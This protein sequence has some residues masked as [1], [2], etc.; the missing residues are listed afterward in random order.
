MGRIAALFAQKFIE[1]FA[2]GSGDAVDLYRRVGLDPK[3][4]IEPSLM[5]EDSEFYGLLEH[6]S[7]LGSTGRSIAVQVGSSMRCDDYGAFGLS[8]KS[9]PNLLESFQR[10]ERFGKVVTSLANFRVVAGG[11]SAFMEVIPDWDDRLGAV[12]TK[13]LAVAAATALSREVCQ[14]ELD[15][16]SVSFTH[17]APVDTS[18]FEAHFECPVTFGASRDGFEIDQAFLD[19]PNRFGDSGFSRFFD[20]HLEEE[21]EKLEDAGGLSQQIRVQISESLSGG[22]PTLPEIAS[23]LHMSDRTL[24]RRLLDQ[25]LSFR[26]V[27]DQTRQQFAKSLL[28]RTAYSLSEISFLTGFSEQSAF[29]RAFKRWTG[30]TPQSYRREV[31]SE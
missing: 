29:N 15:L 10:V 19:S 23:R 24:Q 25:G 8:F 1:T 2:G 4:S 6:M 30:S 21:L 5:L 17:E 3:R 7:A 31:A 20:Q 13:E 16:R 27:V 22:V 18:V 12:M 14:Q 26:K 28:S 11:Q 9:A